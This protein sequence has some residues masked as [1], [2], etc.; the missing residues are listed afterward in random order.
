M[1]VRLDHDQHRELHAYVDRHGRTCQ[2]VFVRA[3]ETYMAIYR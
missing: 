2:D 3:L 1:T